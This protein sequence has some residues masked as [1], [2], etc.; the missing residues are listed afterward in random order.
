MRELLEAYLD[1]L[2]LLRRA[3]LTLVNLRQRLE[4]FISYLEEIGIT[5]L[6]DVSRR[7]IIEYQRYRKQFINRFGR[8][9]SIAVE[10]RHFIAVRNFFRWLV[11]EGYLSHN[12]AAKMELL[13]EPQRLPR[14]VLTNAEMKR[15]LKKPD[16]KTLRGYRDR[17]ILEVLYSSGIRRGELLSL[18]CDDVDPEG[19]FLRINQGKGRKDRI[20]PV[21]K[22]AVRYL[23]TYLKGIRPFLLKDG[24][25]PWLFVSTLGRKMGRNSLG[26]MIGR[27]AQSAGLNKT[28]TPH[29]FRRS[30]ATEMIKNKANLYH[31][32]EILGHSKLET[33]NKYCQLA[34][35]DLKE[36]HRKYHPREKEQDYS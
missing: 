10:N 19:G 30:C 6:R 12:P 9:D 13:K 1:Y 7:H 29:T 24:D 14:S 33:L 11:K 2:K 4:A 16:T 23:E 32:K 34:L 21:G 28:V 36:A 5:D 3:Q 8:H 18:R 15:L 20:V 26:W 27:Y 22:I 31:V 25:I 35:V 17:T